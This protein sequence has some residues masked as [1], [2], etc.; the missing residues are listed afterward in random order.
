MPVL[1]ST[2]GHRASCSTDQPP[3]GTGRAIGDRPMSEG[4]WA[5]ERADVLD[6]GQGE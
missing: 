3:P 5:Q 1:W 4:E 2:G 6:A